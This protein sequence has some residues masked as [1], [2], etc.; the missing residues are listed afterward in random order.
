MSESVR[1][2]IESRG[3]SDF[4]VMQMLRFS[5]DLAYWKRLWKKYQSLGGNF[6]SAH[7]VS[8]RT[9]WAGP[10]PK[11]HMQ[12]VGKKLEKATSI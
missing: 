9:P 12:P 10:P 6:D 1:K 11:Y 8:V 2:Y 3:Y 5:A 7:G 4:Q